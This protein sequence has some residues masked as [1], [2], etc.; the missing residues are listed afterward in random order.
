MGNVENIFL[1]VFATL[2]TLACTS[3]IALRTNKDLQHVSH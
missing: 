3:S 1:C 2:M